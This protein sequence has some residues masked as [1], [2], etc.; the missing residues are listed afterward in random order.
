MLLPLLLASLAAPDAP[1]PRIPEFSYRIVRAFPHDKAAFTEGLF[2]ANGCL[3]EST[4]LSGKSS[5]RKVDLATGRILQQVS[6]PPAYFGEGIVAWKNQIFQLT[7]TTE[8]GFI[9]DL[10][11]FARRGNFH[12]PGQGWS[13]THDGRRLIMDDGTPVLRFWDPGSLRPIGQVTVTA[14]GAPVDYLNELEWVK[15]KLYANVWHTD[16]I[17]MIDTSHGKVVGWIDLTG[18]FP[19]GDRLSGPESEEQVLNGIAYDPARDRLFVTGKYWPHLYQIEI[20]RR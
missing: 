15:D 19:A 8:I 6:L 9:Y 12:Y 14:D 7:Y 2:H 10:A 11:T 4:G 20:H 13:L 16:R 17:A 5:L 1:T 3:Y 18:L